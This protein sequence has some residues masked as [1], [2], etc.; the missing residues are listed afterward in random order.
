MLADCPELLNSNE[1]VSGAKMCVDYDL[2]ENNGVPYTITVQWHL[3][4]F[5]LSLCNSEL[6]SCFLHGVSITPATMQLNFPS[7]LEYRSL[8]A[9]CT[10]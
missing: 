7:G 6:L 2:W 5:V 4:Y 9:N 1:E 10:S 3:L 8:F